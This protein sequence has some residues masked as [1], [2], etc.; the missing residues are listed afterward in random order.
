MPDDTKAIARRSFVG[1]SI[2]GLAGALLGGG[3]GA[4]F[5]R[6][7]QPFTARPPIIIKGSS[8]ELWTLGGG[9]GLEQVGSTAEYW[10][11]GDGSPLSV[12]LVGFSNSL[13]DEDW[14]DIGSIVIELSGPGKLSIK[15]D[16]NNQR[17]V[18]E[19]NKVLNNVGKKHK[20][21]DAP[22][23]KKIYG[24]YPNNT[25]AF[26]PFEGNDLKFFMLLR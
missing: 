6:E 18:Y 14:D 21:P 12:E 2:G 7:R 5:F 1:G 15:I 26:G 23:I 25:P 17:V 16:Q 8:L 19:S 20:H 10:V 9:Q 3:L 13:P 24:K 11:R 22:Q 4:W